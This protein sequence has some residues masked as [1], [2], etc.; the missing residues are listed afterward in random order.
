MK[1]ILRLKHWQIFSIIIVVEIISFVLTSSDFKI[2][3]ISSLYLAVI[4]A[5]I[6]FIL[7]FSWTLI[8][9]LFLNNIKGNA[10]H[11]KN[12]ILILAI[13]CCIQG[14]SYLNFQRL[15]LDNEFIPF[16]IEFISTLLTFWGIYYT[17]YQVAKSL[18]SIELDREAKFSECILDALALFALPFGV[19]FIQP[20]VNRILIVVEQIE[21]EK[22]NDIKGSRLL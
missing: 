16:W 9:G 17:F 4:A 12:W 7:F 11:F 1:K 15:K 21:K 10:Y 3:S 2:G 22:E 6:T 18:K 19:W 20:R 5:I 8:I 14:Y 13:F